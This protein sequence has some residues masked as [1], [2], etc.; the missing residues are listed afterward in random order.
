VAASSASL[1]ATRPTALLAR[2]RTV[3]AR[4]TVVVRAEEAAAKKEEEAPKVGFV[5]CITGHN[6]SC[7]SFER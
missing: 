1:R 5:Y 6:E 4:R 3:S 7:R 2:S